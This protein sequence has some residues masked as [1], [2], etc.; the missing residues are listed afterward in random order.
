M[1]FR[2]CL[3]L[4]S[5]SFVACTSAK[6]PSDGDVVAPTHTVPT[7]TP[8]ATA[9]P[10]AEAP[11]VDL[12]VHLADYDFAKNPDLPRRIADNPH[13]YYRFINRK[14]SQ[15]VCKEVASRKLPTPV[16]PIHGDAHLEQYTVTDLGR[17]ITDLDDAR[18]GPASLDLMRM[19]TSI[20]IAATMVEGLPKGA[21]DTLA[22]SF[23]DTYLAVMAGKGQPLKAPSVVAKLSAKMDTDRKGFLEFVDKNTQSFDD[24]GV[25]QKVIMDL[26]TGFLPT[27]AEEVHAALKKKVNPH[28]AKVKKSGPIKLGI[29]SA[30]DRKFLVRVEGLTDKPDDDLVVEVK[31]VRDLSSDG[32]STTDRNYDPRRFTVIEESQLFQKEKALF[33]VPRVLADQNYWV[34]FWNP[35]F[36][37]LKVQKHVKT[38]SELAELSTEMATLIGNEHRASRKDAPALSPDVVR[39]LLALA[40]DLERATIE[41]HAAFRA[42][43]DGGKP[44]VPTTSASK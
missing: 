32:C 10:V 26:M 44:P 14:F 27:W 29:G 5:L 6:P 15:V 21:G 36:K 37:D 39:G 22:Q 38:Y 7:S 43:V 34:S 24:T 23:F 18:S 11:E 19:A 40:K 3:A 1:R 30:L 13:S 41:G 31:A 33:F 9:A 12:T 17:G 42:E 28:F 2:R 20:R 4:L 8:S 16:G 35:N 25:E